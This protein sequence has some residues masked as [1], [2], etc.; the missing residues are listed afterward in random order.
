MTD[1]NEPD[2]FP[3]G[4]FDDWAAVYDQDVA[5]DTFPFT[6]YKRVL[7]TVLTRAEVQPGM[8]VLDLGAGTGNLAALFAARGCDLWCTDFSA[9][10]LE[11]AREKLPAA[12]FF[13]HDLRRPFPPVLKRRFDRIV[14]A[15]VFHHFE[16]PEKIA[17]VERLAREHLGTGGRLVIA[18]IS[19]PTAA[20]R[21]RLRRTLGD[22]WE[23][24]FYW[25]AAETLPALHAR[26]LTAAYEQVSDCAGVYCITPNGEKVL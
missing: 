24:E 11:R 5:G 14:S 2:L 3:P 16:L 21:D 12:R 25:I 13:L 23:D 9:E 22:E 20:D 15:Y 4:E 10:M 8:S 17:L 19:F 26:G 18:D 6:G 1:P 7:E